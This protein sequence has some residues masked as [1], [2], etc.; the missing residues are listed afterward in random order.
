MFCTPFSLF[1]FFFVKLFFSFCKILFSV[2]VET[3]G[4]VSTCRKK[5]LLTILTHNK[6][7]MK[8][9]FSQIK[10][11]KLSKI[12]LE[13]EN[14]KHEFNSVKDSLV[15]LDSIQND[16]SNFITIMQPIIELFEQPEE[17]PSQE[18]IIKEQEEQMKQLE[19]VVQ[20]ALINLFNKEENQKAIMEF[21]S[22]LQG[23]AAGF[24]GAG[25]DMETILD[26]DGYVDP[27]R[28]AVMWF[29][30]RDK[31]VGLPKGKGTPMSTSGKTGAY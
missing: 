13:I 18:Q 25:F 6:H 2:P 23:G 12:E 10:K 17:E 24:E 20:N 31:L 15:L 28:A 29:T 1:F 8:N 9:P 7:S 26:K 14:F 22:R 4:G 21:A 5:Y 30:N 16:V 27:L 3:K 19:Q 11:E